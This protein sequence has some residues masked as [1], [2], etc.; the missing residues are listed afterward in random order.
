MPT[1]GRAA[2]GVPSR[3]RRPV[4]WRC[5]PLAGAPTQDAAA[6][7]VA[8]PSEHAERLAS[9]VCGGLLSHFGEGKTFVLRIQ[10][11]TTSKDK[12]CGVEEGND[13]DGGQGR[14][15]RCFLDLFV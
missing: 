8:L 2:A 10:N 3:A 7:S 15:R 12:K 13:V 4:P 9:W 5:G 11:S 6:R 1:D 14:E